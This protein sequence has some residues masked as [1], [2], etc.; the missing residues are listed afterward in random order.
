MQLTHWKA[1]VPRK[2]WEAREQGD[3]KWDGWVASQTWCMSLK[4]L[5]VLLVD[6]EAY[7]A[8]LQSM[9]SQ[10]LEQLSDWTEQNGSFWV[11]KVIVH[12]GTLFLEMKD[13]ETGVLSKVQIEL[14]NLDPNTGFPISSLSFNFGQVVHS[15][16]FLMLSYKHWV[17]S[18]LRLS[19]AHILLFLKKKKKGWGEE[20]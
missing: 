3:S 11:C 2:D 9:D 4:Y 6:K 20:F 15:Q 1:T 13:Y 12:C 5:Q 16:S 10:R 18:F 17:T 19:E 7:M 14:G 8:L